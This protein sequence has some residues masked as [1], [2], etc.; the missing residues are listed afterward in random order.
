MRRRFTL[1]TG[2]RSLRQRA[3]SEADVWRALIFERDHGACQACGCPLFLSTQPK[4]TLDHVVPVAKG[5]SGHH[6]NLQIMCFECN[7]AKGC[8]VQHDA[9]AIGRA[10]A[11]AVDQR[12]ARR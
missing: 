10:A 3:R 9:R 5:G 7:T 12:L 1:T 11:E 8:D 2:H 4:A 6:T